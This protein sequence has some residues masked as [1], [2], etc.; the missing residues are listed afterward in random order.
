MG[1]AQVNFSNY[2]SDQLDILI[3]S[4]LDEASLASDVTKALSEDS[5]W[6]TL[7]RAAKEN[8]ILQEILNADCKE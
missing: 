2:I 4:S 8:Q 1:R 5:F 3:R 6:Q 7:I